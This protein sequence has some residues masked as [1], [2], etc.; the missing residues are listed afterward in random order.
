MKNGKRYNEEFKREAVRLVKTGNGNISSVSKDLGV[1]EQTL[2]NWVH[3]EQI[4]E[5]P[6]QS[7]IIELEKALKE[8]E[9]RIA[10]LE[11]SVEILKKATAIFATSNRK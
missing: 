4:K 6:E 1:A 5:E 10:D 2:R 3:D 11:M 9:K 8:K 7:R